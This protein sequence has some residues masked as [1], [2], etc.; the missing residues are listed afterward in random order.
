VGDVIARLLPQ[1]SR[2]VDPSRRSTARTRGPWSQ[3]PLWPPDL[4]AVAATLV[5]RSDCYAQ[6]RQGSSPT[7]SFDETY[8]DEV[9]TIGRRWPRELKPPARLQEIWRALAGDFDAVVEPSGPKGRIPPWAVAALRLMAI[10]DEASFEMGFVAPTEEP[11]A[12]F[13]HLVLSEAQASLARTPRGERA[14]KH[15]PSSVCWLV[16]LEECCVLP[17]TRT[18]QVGVTLTALSHYLALLP[19]AS[20]VYPRWIVNPREWEGS[21]GGAFNLLLVPYPYNVDGG[22]FKAVPTADPRGVRFFG[23]DQKWI[24]SDR[25]A[26]GTEFAT[27]VL[28]LIESASRDVG[29]VHGVVLPELALD[30]VLYRS[31]ESALARTRTVE[32]LVSGVA[33]REGARSFNEVRSSFFAKGRPVLKLSQS[34]HHRWKLDRG[35]IGRYH[36]GHALHPDSVWWEDIDVSK[37]ECTFYV[38]RPGAALA[39]LVCEDLARLEPV[40]PVVRAVGPNLLIALLLDGPQLERRWPGRY[41]TVLAD[42]PGS[43]VLTLTS[44]GMLRRAFMPGESQTREIALWKEPS[45]AARELRL[46]S[47]AHALAISLNL[48]WEET[49]TFDGRSDQREGVGTSVRLALGG[50]TGVSCAEKGVASWIRAGC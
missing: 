45:D 39:F 23:V 14:L 27:F 32:V 15:L 33:R 43:A 26:A 36:L 21:A 9:Y 47:S 29:C 17:K 40:Q 16:P 1:G 44:L 38:F 4:F 31:L 49:R 41:A 34:K 35:Q 30:E 19:P 18:P 37:R 10:A 20:T 28:G 13:S 42:D 48:S 8:R 24:P 12:R 3:C 46:P 22:C 25:K 5:A 2:P 50:V 6:L 11:E 7:F